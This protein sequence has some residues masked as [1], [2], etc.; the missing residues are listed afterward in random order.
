MISRALPRVKI[1]MLVET[2]NSKLMSTLWR[3]KGV[4][5]TPDRP[6]E[7][8][9]PCPALVLVSLSPSTSRTQRNVV[10]VHYLTHCSFR[11]VLRPDH[12][13]LDSSRAVRDGHVA[14]EAHPPFVRLSAESLGTS[15]REFVVVELQYDLEPYLALAGIGEG[16]AG[17]HLNRSAAGS[18]VDP[19]GLRKDLTGRA[20]G[21]EFGH[22]EPTDV[23]AVG[24]VLEVGRSDDASDRSGAVESFPG[25]LERILVQDRSRLG[26]RSSDL[27]VLQHV[28]LQDE[29]TLIR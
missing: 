16:D 23:I 17:V 26:P 28:R 1:S 27:A 11:K 14:V 20:L 8:L 18:D 5:T 9:G 10:H 13:A 29:Q 22:D 4:D 24:A 3:R 6:S 15:P 19:I 21:R 12:D 2:S 7:P 25:E